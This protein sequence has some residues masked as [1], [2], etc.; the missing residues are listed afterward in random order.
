MYGNVVSTMQNVWNRSKHHA[1]Y[2]KKVARSECMEKVR[3]HIAPT[4]LVDVK[5]SLDLLRFSSVR[6]GL[7]KLY[8]LLP[9][10]TK[11][12]KTKTRKPPAGQKNE[13]EILEELDAMLLQTS[14]SSN[15]VPSSSAGYNAHTAS[16]YIYLSIQLF[17]HAFIYCPHH[18][19]CM[20]RTYLKKIPSV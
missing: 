13:T 11:V 19:F 12:S 1:E 16:P 17:I 5:S 15:R 14:S 18:T 20:G 2:M 7:I 3:L 4:R 8:G 10:R 9:P 6:R